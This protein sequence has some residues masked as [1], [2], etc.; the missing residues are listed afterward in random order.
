MPNTP[1]RRRVPPMNASS[2][3]AILTTA[4]ARGDVPGVSAI[5]VDR[6][7][8]TYEG[9]AGLSRAGVD[10]APGTVV[11]IASM[12]KA[13][14]SLAA[15]QQVERGALTLDGPAGDIAPELAS[16]Q[17]L[18][19]DGSQR[20]P[21]TPVT[22]R[23]LLTHTAGFAY[24]F[25]DERMAAYVAAHGGEDPGL[26]APL[27]C[28]P[29][30]R[31]QY[32]INTDWAGALVEAVSG[33]DLATYMAANVLG[34][35][36][37]VDSAFTVKPGSEGGLAAV[38]VRGQG[39]AWAEIPAPGEMTMALRGKRIASGGGGLNS[40]ARD[41]GRFLRMML[42]DGTLDGERL[43]GADGMAGLTTNQVGATVVGAW[44]SM[45]PALSNDVDLTAGGT[46]RHTLGFL[47]SGRESPTGA[48]ADTL[49]WGGIFNSYYWVDRARGVAGATFSQFFPF[50]DARAWAL[51][52]AFQS[53]V[54]SET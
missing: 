46:T 44:K 2:L 27:V 49:S 30:A 35:L 29:G 13:L 18:E 4:V 11:R 12:T 8:I 24:G 50:M 5:A 23:G 33:Q 48:A 40:T 19:A 26:H 54:Y 20:A 45:A 47:V 53:G 17:V 10:M 16:L 34:P 31:W 21:A 14:T 41:Y 37:M 36:R 9:A 1:F 43:I 42:G 28:D 32:G 51:H 6:Q 15:L 39:G 25:T 7:G 38:H 52:E 3:D 22:L